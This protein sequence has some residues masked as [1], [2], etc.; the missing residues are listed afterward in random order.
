MDFDAFIAKG[1]DEHVKDSPGVAARLRA[2]G[3]ALVTQP[4]QIVP[5]AHLAHHVM[6][7]HLGRWEDGLHFQQRL[8]ASPLCT[9][10]SDAAQALRRFMA[11]LQ[12]A[13]GAAD[14]SAALGA[15]D[16]IRVTAMA[17]A[18][19]AGHDGARALSLF[20]GA[21]A[22]AE[23]AALPDTDASTRALAIAGN[24][25]A[26]TIEEMPDRSADERRLMIL[27]AQT[28][29]RFWALAGGWLETERAE[30]RLTKTWLQAGDLGR[31]RQHARNCLD[32]VAAHDNV[33][34][35]AF[36]GWEALGCVE[37][38]AGNAAGHLHAIA[39][40]EAAF[41]ALS[42]ADRSW[43]QADLDKLRAPS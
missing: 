27:A 32:I 9:P 43:C 35:E 12:L 39:Q 23:A 13:S 34:L 11:S 28:A 21:L 38:A 37:R 15:S 40:V 31:A 24:G 33:A 18:S 10:G 16:R 19:L 42:E 30:F 14:E 5:L 4:S 20:E 25:L 6:G 29:R 36:F 2:E 7:E 1:W 22:L 26:A 17:A 3:L 8:A 41:A